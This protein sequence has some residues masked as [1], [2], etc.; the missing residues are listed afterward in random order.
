[1][2]VYLQWFGERPTVQPHLSSYASRRG[3]AQHHQTDHRSHRPGSRLPE[4]VRLFERLHQM[5][6]LA[7]LG[8]SAEET[9]TAPQGEAK[10][11]EVILKKRWK[12]VG[13]DSASVV[14]AAVNNRIAGGRWMSALRGR[15]SWRAPRL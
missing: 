10:V 7:A 14:T 15:G 3:T 12:N 1:M 11:A 8:I 2:A 4:P 13:K 6:R 9:S 5:D